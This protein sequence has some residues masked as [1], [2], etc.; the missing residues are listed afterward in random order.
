MIL[1]TTFLIDLFRKNKNAVM[2][3]EELDKSNEPIFTT[4]ITIFELWQGSDVKQKDKKN[5]LESSVEKFPLLYF[6]KGSAKQGGKI[7]LE[8]EEQ[9]LIIDPEDCMIAGIARHTSQNVL[10]NDNHF[11]RIKGIKVETY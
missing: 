3:A 7:S 1:D 9:G 2:K 8:L 10:T 6:D 11:L 5:E 4:P